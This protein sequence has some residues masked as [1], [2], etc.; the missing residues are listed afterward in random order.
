[1]RISHFSSFLNLFSKSLDLK[2]SKSFSGLFLMLSGLLFMTLTAAAQGNIEQGYYDN[3]DYKLAFPLSTKLK[4][5]ETPARKLQNWDSFLHL[6]SKDKSVDI[7]GFYEEG[8][9]I[10]SNSQYRRVEALEEHPD[11]RCT[12]SKTLMGSQFHVKSVLVCTHIGKLLATSYVSSFIQTSQG[13]T[14]LYFHVLV[15]KFEIEET[16]EDVVNSAKGFYLYD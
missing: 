3:L 6:Q 12:E 4:W 5:K 16:L 7:Y 15:T 11:F 1:M 14:E 13:L 8:G 9:D 2:Y 10:A